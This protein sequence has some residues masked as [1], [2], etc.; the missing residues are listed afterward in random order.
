MDLHCE[1]F[2]NLLMKYFIAR[3]DIKNTGNVQNN[4][5]IIHANKFNANIYYPSWF[6]NN[7]G[8]GMVIQ[9][10]CGV[11]DFELKCVNDG[12]LKILLRAIVHRDKKGN[13]FPVYI[14][15]TKL[16][17]NGTDILKKN[18]LVNYDAPYLFEQKVKDSEIIKIHVEW[19]PFNENSD[20]VNPMSSIHKKNLDFNFI[21]NSGDDS[22]IADAHNIYHFPDSP[23]HTEID[24][25]YMRP[26]KREK[27]LKNFNAFLYRDELSAISY[28]DALVLPGNNGKGGVI[29]C[30]GHLVEESASVWFGGAY[31]VEDNQI[32][33]DERTVVFLGEYSASTWGHAHA[34]L[35]VRLVLSVSKREC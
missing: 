1:E 34:S 16:S 27:V 25:S 26:L 21:K 18:K 3:I 20:F 14:D 22:N 13:R 5:S 11:L 19:M 8:K 12:I 23:I 29:D 30:N 32:E 15:Y 4:V 10:D 7:H 33:Y 24:L 28:D 9:S 2:Q 6:E 35:F 17:I 31:D